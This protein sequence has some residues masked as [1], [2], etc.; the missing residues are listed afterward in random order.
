M[1]WFVLVPGACHGGWWFEPL[2]AELSAAGHTADA[3][4][5]AGLD[6][7][8]TDV[9]PGINLDTHVQ[10][11]VDLLATREDDV[12][13]V[14]HSYAGSV[15]SAVADQRASQVRALVYI[16]AFVPEDGESCW[17]M[18]DDEQRQWYGSA[19]ARTGLAVDPMPFF[20]DRARPQ[21]LGTLMQRS[22]LTGA[23][24]AVPTLTYALAADPDW[25]S[26]SPFVPVADRLR[27]DPR[28][29]VVDLD[30]THNVLA[31]G[32]D[33]VRQLLLEHA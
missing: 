24:K 29:K 30:A 27:S 12:V 9:A 22:L 8:A 15:I 16:D 20:D 1:T 5:L 6:P 13:L 23:Y 3:V 4:T 7:A 31:K 14:G 11:V 2:A 19:S 26:H 33:R 17:S 25:A 32:T 10:Q 28:W 21:P 18:T